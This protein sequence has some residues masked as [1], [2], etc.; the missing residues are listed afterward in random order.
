ML[1]NLIEFVI[2]VGV[3]GIIGWITNVLAIKML[4]RPYREISVFGIKIQGVIPKRKKAL[5]ES[6]ARTINEELISVKDITNALN[7]MTVEDEVDKIVDKVIGVRFKEEIT[8]KMPMVGMF[9]ND[10]I[11]A[12]IKEFVKNAIMNNK[13]EIIEAL[14]QKIEEKIDFKEIIKEKI[15]NFSLLQLERMILSIAKNELHEIEKFGGVLGALIGLFQ[16]I[17]TRVIS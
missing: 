15:E 5:A 16:F 6:L 2:M 1:K 8:A 7:S 3:G 17:I 12:K 10:G 13:D 14:V 4:F 9:L 11:M